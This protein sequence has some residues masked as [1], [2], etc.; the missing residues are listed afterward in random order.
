MYPFYLEHRGLKIS[1]TLLRAKSA[2]GSVASPSTELGK[3]SMGYSVAKLH[4]SARRMGKIKSQNSGRILIGEIENYRT[5]DAKKTLEQ[6]RRASNQRN[7]LWKKPKQGCNGDWQESRVACLEE[8]KK[9][10]MTNR[11]DLV[12]PFGSLKSSPPCCD[13]DQH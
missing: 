9:K 3:Y 7:G 10:N 8:Q 12:F 4:R 11:A 2:Q 6:E 5:G 1:T 13:S